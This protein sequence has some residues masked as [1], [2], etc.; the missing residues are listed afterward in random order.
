MDLKLFALGESRTFGE[1]IAR[2]LGLSLAAHEE[3]EFED[4]EH[5]ARPLE[6][7]RGADVF[8]IHS[9][10]GES[11]HSV[12]DKLCRLLFFIGALRDAGAF[13]L[14]AL[15]PYLCYARK[16]RRTRARDPVTTRYLAALFEAVGVDCVVAL[17]VHDLAAFQNAFRCR[18][19]H[20]VARPL[21]IE[22]F[23]GPL[24]D[25]DVV[26]VSPDPGGF[27]RADAFRRS[28]AVALGRPDVPLGFM[29][30]RRSGGEVSGTSL[31]AEVAGRTVIIVDDLV[32]TGGTLQ[33]A[34][35][36]A[37][38][39]GARAVHAAATH[40][41][42]TGGAEAL[43]SESALASIVTTDSVE[44]RDVPPA[45]APVPLVRLSTARLFAEAVRRLHDGGS[46]SELA[47]LE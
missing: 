31:F 9:L 1:R 27:K 18:S 36:A 35:R 5:K 37:R 26:V 39:A 15:V 32:S 22:H 30:K 19:E 34:A 10:H 41:L 21:F 28:L 12:D 33:R 4:G 2:E 3:R 17:D 29:E 44:V 47:G 20:L 13:R 38:E 14:T 42:F 16:E 25:A 7:V 23:A 11:A 6:S 40:G 8:V 24:R 43:F 46:M 45:D